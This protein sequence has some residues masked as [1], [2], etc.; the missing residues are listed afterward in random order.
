V[1]EWLRRSFMIVDEKLEKKEALDELA[2]YRRDVPPAKSPLMNMLQKDGSADG[3]QSVEDM[4]LDAVGCTA[5]LVYV[6]RTKKKIYVANAGDS[7][8]IMGVGGKMTELSFDHKPTNKEEKDRIEAA[9]SEVN[10]EGRVDGN[11][12]L[13]RS[14]GDLKYKQKKAFSPEEQPI[15]ANPDTYVYDLDDN[16]DFILMGCDGIWEKNSN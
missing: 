4:N 11:L 8:C 15:T 16:I 9:G 12:N 14:L 5:N 2:Q 3:E 10:A 13:S 6:D 1:K 7:R